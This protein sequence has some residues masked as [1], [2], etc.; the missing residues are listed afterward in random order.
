MYMISCSFV[1]VLHFIMSLASTREKRSN[2]GNRMSRLLE[3]EQEDDFYKTTYGGFAEVWS[4]QIMNVFEC[5]GK[6]IS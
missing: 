4:I 3:E 5:Y 1:K 2:A 6:N